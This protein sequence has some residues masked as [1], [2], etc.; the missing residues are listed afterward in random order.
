MF[1][2]P[3]EEWLTFECVATTLLSAYPIVGIRSIST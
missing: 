1:I 3:N 2:G